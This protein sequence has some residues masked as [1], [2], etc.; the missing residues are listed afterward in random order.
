MYDENKSGVWIF[1]AG[2][3]AFVV[4]LCIVNE[5]DFG[6]GRISFEHTAVEAFEYIQARVNAAHRR[7]FF[8]VSP[9]IVNL[10]LMYVD[11]ANR[12]VIYLHEHSEEMMQMFREVVLNSPLVEFRKYAQ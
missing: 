10:R 7:R 1:L 8:S 6:K 5:I 11:D 4:V 12:V 9:A 3:C 2:I